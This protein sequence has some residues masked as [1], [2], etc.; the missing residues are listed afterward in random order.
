MR[1][2]FDDKDDDGNVQRYA[3]NRFR[4]TPDQTFSVGLDWTIPMGGAQM[5]LRPAYNWQS[6][7][8]FED[9]NDEMLSQDAYGLLSLRAGVRLA[10]GRWDIG[11]WGNN[12]T[13]EKFLI[14]G[15]NTGRL[16]GT[17]TF[18]PGNPRMYGVTATVKF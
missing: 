16:F 5:Y 7:V 18:I 13:G 10:D 15:G 1:A 6:K 4:L 17:P 8:Y 2:R 12:L 11:V 3:G 14:D 9:D